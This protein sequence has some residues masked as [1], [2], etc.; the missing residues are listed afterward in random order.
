M[1]VILVMGEG[2]R[3]SCTAFFVFLPESWKG[4][5]KPRLEEEEEEE[6][7]RG[8]LLLLLLLALSG[9]GRALYLSPWV[10]M[11]RMPSTKNA[12]GLGSFK[13]VD[14]EEEEEEGR[15]EGVASAR[16]RRSRRSFR[17]RCCKFWSLSI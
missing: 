17:S 12:R 9:T 4:K 11:E 13:E 16:A 7:G 5:R 2:G 6:E 10:L 8:V 15:E 1:V 3:M 14:E